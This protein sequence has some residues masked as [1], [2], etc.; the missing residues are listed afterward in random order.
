MPVTLD[1]LTS[2]FNIASNLST[3]PEFTS[4]IGFTHEEVR[5]IVEEVVLQEDEEKVYHDLKEN[6]DGYRFSEESEEKTFNSTLVM[7][8]LSNYVI[9][10][11]PPR[12]LMDSNMNT[13]GDKIKRIVELVKPDKNYE[14]VNEILFNNQISGTLKSVVL[15]SSIYTKNDLIT[16]LFHLGYLTILSAGIQ[17]KFTIP[18]TITR[19][20]YSEYL[21]ELLKIREGYKIETERITQAIVDLGEK[22][23]VFK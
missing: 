10:K 15:D 6:Y 5:K 12:N 17:T 18:N 14:A 11:T 16:M 1:N 2:G 13:S 19:T 3:D 21:A 9:R 23:M 22:L 20:I 7:Y 4:M 8:Y